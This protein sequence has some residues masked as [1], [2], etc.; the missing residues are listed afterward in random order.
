MDDVLS[1]LAEADIELQRARTPSVLSLQYGE[2]ALDESGYQKSVQEIQAI[3]SFAVEADSPLS[4]L[5]ITPT[6]DLGAP[7]ETF[8]K[9]VLFR[10]EGLA[11]IPRFSFVKCEC[12]AAFFIGI[13]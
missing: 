8:V 9:R 13:Y 3:P 6:T 1:T 5:E 4:S 7:A 2:W 12:L 11:A 10:L